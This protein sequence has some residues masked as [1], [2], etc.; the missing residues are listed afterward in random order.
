MPLF[1]SLSL[2][3]SKKALSARADRFFV[4]HGWRIP[5]DTHSE[6]IH[7]IYGRHILEIITSIASTTSRASFPTPTVL[8][9]RADMDM[10]DS[11]PFHTFKFLA[12]IPVLY[13]PASMDICD[14][15]HESFSPSWQMGE[16]YNCPVKLAC[17]HAFGLS[18]LASWLFSPAFDNHCPF[19]RSPVIEKRSLPVQ[20]LETLATV[21][22]RYIDLVDRVQTRLVVP[23][24]CF[25]HITVGYVRLE[26]RWAVEDDL[27]KRG[28]SHDLERVRMLFYVYLDTVV[29]GEEQIEHQ[30]ALLREEDRMRPQ[31]Q[32]QRQPVFG[33]RA[34]STTELLILL[35]RS[36]YSTVMP[37]LYLL[38]LLFITVVVRRVI[39]HFGSMFLPSMLPSTPSILPFS[40]ARMKLN[41]IS[42]EIVGMVSHDLRIR[43]PFAE[44]SC[45]IA[46]LNALPPL[47]ELI[48]AAEH[49]V[50][51]K[52]KDRL[53]RMRDG[54]R[55][56][57]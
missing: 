23:R 17:G 6:V 14:N 22:R 26:I 32:L 51:G 20:F 9:V 56:D 42:D 41:N 45:F 54:Q 46:F 5:S 12:K 25:D 39:R 3:V 44:F 15:C 16:I 57:R 40:D 29:S 48:I 30:W 21:T 50:L 1:F 28:I 4:Y 55:V 13:D 2:F 11:S 47:A 24:F 27:V 52:L 19:C 53:H 36:V 49:S 18:C 31:N 34:P 8:E 37:V 38:I 33:W 43:T 10:E 35:S 7:S